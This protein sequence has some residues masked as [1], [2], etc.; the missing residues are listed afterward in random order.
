MRL[1]LAGGAALAKMKALHDAG[2]APLEREQLLRTS[3]LLYSF[4]PVTTKQPTQMR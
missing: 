1:R 3:R 4:P 2:G